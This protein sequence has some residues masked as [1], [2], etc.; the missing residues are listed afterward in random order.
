MTR[1]STALDRVPR[2]VCVDKPEGRT[3]FDVVR[4]V[5]RISGYRRVGHG[6]TLDPFATGLLVVGLGP[7]TRLMRYLTEGPKEYVAEIEFGRET[8]S[9]DCTGAVIRES[10]RLPEAGELPDALAGFTGELEQVPPRLS[11]IH[12]DGERSYRRVRRG[13]EVALAARTVRVDEFE[14]IEYEPPHARVRVACGGGTYIRSLARDLG[15]ELQSAAHLSALR[16]TRVGDFSL[17][18]AVTL[19]RLAEDWATGSPGLAP[20]ELVRGWA[21]LDLDPDQVR[22]VRN[23]L[24]PEPEWFG[25]PDWDGTPDRIALLDAGGALVA[26]ASSREGSPGKGLRLALVLPEAG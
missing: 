3:S 17:D 8:D 24:Q 10:D 21:S 1:R 15:R 13:E 25:R 11:A 23:G 14:L 16:R 12:V 4:E 5:R 18:Q 20:A 22:A 9:E 6:G 2:L 7:A 19:E 26:I